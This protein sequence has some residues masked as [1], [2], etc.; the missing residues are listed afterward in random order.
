LR[1][2]EAIARMGP[3]FVYVLTVLG[4]GDLVS[5]STAGAAYGYSLIWILALGLVFRFVWV[6]V[7]AKYVLVTGESLVQGYARVGRWVIWLILISV[8]VLMH[9]YNMYGIV[10]SGNTVHMLFP[11]PTQYSTTIWSLFFAF[12]A[13][14]M[15]YWGGYRA[16]E[17][18]C[19]ILM[20]IMAASLVVVVIL[21][22]PDP[23]EILQGAFI[24]SIPEDR[25]SYSVMF[26][27][28]ALVGT[29][30][31]SVMNLTYAYFIHEKGW[32][33]LSY[34]KQQRFDLV[35]G[36]VCLFVMG[37][38]LQIAAGATVRP[39]GIDLKDAEDMVRIFSEVQGVAGLIIFSLGLWGAAFSTVVGTTVGCSLIVADLSRFLTD[40]PWAR[41]RNREDARRHPVYRACVIFWC[42]SPLY[43][44]YTGV[45]P[46][47]LVLAVS[48]LAA[49]VVPVLTP[50]LIKITSDKSLMGEHKNSWLTNAIL[51]LMVLVAIYFTYKNL[52]EMWNSYM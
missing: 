37:G 36:V 40:R 4:T 27:V 5:H 25:G 39:L 21:S 42:F 32:R 24:P 44:L 22:R 45:S 15:A 46:V 10:M 38:L 41:K 14:A 35:F 28:M 43:I 48:A 50:V 18:F 1:F 34:L 52:V 29:M 31:G 2:G 47:W 8:A 23:T 16:L 11:L 26:V 33:D 13:F 30:A 9:L 7:S 17:I 6:N 51:T 49:A 19:K 12:L 3:G 20:A